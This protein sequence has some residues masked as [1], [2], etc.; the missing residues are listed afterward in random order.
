MPE[1]DKKPQTDVVQDSK[2]TVKIAT[3]QALIELETVKAELKTLKAEND[4]LKGELKTTNG[5]LDAQ[6]RSKLLTEVKSISK[7][8]NEQLMHMTTGELQDFIE[9][10]K[11]ILPHRKPITFAGETEETLGNMTLGDLFAFKRK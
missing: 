10:Y 6:L 8:S 9:T 1:P 3:D 7:L 5:L 11:N 2:D 4:A